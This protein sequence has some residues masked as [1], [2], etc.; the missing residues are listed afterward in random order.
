MTASPDDMR[1]AVAGYVEEIHRSYVAQAL[2][3]PPGVQGRMS[4]LAGTGAGRAPRN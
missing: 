4:L 1:Q 3:F 2:T